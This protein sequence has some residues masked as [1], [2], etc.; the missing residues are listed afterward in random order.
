MNI[1]HV[2]SL[3]LAQLQL[4][5][6]IART[7]NLSE[8]AEELG[9]TQSAASHALAKL[10]SELQDPVFVRTSEG[11]RPTPFGIRLAGSARSAL[12][13]LQGV[14]TRHTE[15]VPEHSRRT[16]NIIDRKSVV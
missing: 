13:T 16:F 3:Y 4:V 11:M 10:R 2:G 8:A 14:L 9:L 1:M 12:D 5:E 7:G 15:F 6:A